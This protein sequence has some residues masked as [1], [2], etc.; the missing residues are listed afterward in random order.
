[1]TPPK[2]ERA[3]EYYVCSRLSF[4]APRTRE[5]IFMLA[6]VQQAVRDYLRNLDRIKP[7]KYRND[8]VEAKTCATEYLHGSIPHA[9]MAGI[10]REYIYRLLADVGHPI[11]A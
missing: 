10:E 6:I 7:G 4:Q 1:M 11:D 5:G 3:I 9:H 2:N 8:C